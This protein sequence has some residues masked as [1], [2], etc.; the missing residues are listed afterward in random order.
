MEN[1]DHDKLSRSLCRWVEG[2]QHFET[3]SQR[4]ERASQEPCR[5][6][7]CAVCNSIPEKLV[8]LG[9]LRPEGHHLQSVAIVCNGAKLTRLTRSR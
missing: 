7:K 3:V 9:A 2:C 4:V 1:D 8:I 5:A 6:E